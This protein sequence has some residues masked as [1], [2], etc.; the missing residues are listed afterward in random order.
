MSKADH[1]SAHSPVLG[2]APPG[3]RRV[4]EIPSCGSYPSEKASPG[5]PSSATLRCDPARRPGRSALYRLFGLPFIPT[6]ALWGWAEN[7]GGRGCACIYVS[8]L[9]R[10]FRRRI[11]HTT[12][13]LFN[14]TSTKQYSGKN[15]QVIVKFFRSLI[16]EN[17]GSWW[18]WINIIE[19]CMNEKCHETIMKKPYSIM[20]G[21]N[22][23]HLHF[24]TIA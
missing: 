3:S 21:K 23:F 8:C 17:H 9:V 7:G 16:G 1:G 12:Y 14:K 5:R 20:S 10:I 13:F 11:G 4:L 2:P 19:R 15:P 6:R 18:S 22:D 24:V